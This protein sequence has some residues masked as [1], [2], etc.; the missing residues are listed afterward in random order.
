[1]PLKIAKSDRRL[2]LW[3]AAIMLPIILALGMMSSEQEESEIPSSYSP[4][5]HG[6]KAAYLLLEEQGYKVERWEESPTE[7][8]AEPA[9]T[10]LVLASPFRTPTRDEKNSLQLFLTRGGR[11]LATGSTVSLFLPQAETV[12]ELIGSPDW[13]E[14]QPQL[15]SPLTRGGPIRMSPAAY[16]KQDSPPLLAHYAD[17]KDRPIVV[18]YKFGKGEVIWWASATPLSNAGITAAGN[19][20]LLLNS[21]GDNKGVQIL[22]DEYFH[23]YRRSL[24]GY[25]AEPPLKYGLLQCFLLLG[26]LLLTY[27]RRNLPVH[28]AEEK[29]R[30]SPLEFVETLGGLYHRANATRAALEVPYMRFRMAATRRLG[31]KP[32]ITADELA[33]SL[34]NRFGYKDQDFAGLLRRIEAALA[35]DEPGEDTVLNLAQELNRHMR[36]LKLVQENFPHGERVPGAQARA[37]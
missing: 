21:L 4:D 8:P 1:M 15:L 28:P 32:D 10:V 36:N 2:L 37:K 35:Q 24:A 7:L 30:L 11:I 16:W 12:P 20:A 23:G 3:A 14:F 34:Q 29:S 13:K 27:S 22:W 33:R 31:V 18:S 6:A 17:D 19:L 25:M 5:S 26:A 9:G